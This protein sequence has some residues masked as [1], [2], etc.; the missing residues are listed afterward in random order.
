MYSGF[1]LN[2]NANRTFLVSRERDCPLSWSFSMLGLFL[3]QSEI[4]TCDKTRQRLCLRLTPTVRPGNS[5]AA[6]SVSEK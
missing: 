5:K 3:K 2:E 6:G 4:Q 1:Y